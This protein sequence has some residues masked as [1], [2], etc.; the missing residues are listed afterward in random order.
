MTDII[1]G[2]RQLLQDFVAPDL[3]AIQAKQDAQ[4]NSIMAT[5]EAFRAEMRSELTALRA[6]LQVD[7]LNKTHPLSER[8]TA[9]EAK[10]GR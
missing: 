6:T 3:K 1:T 5:L 4:Y 8:L 7:V 2:L 9:I 10:Q